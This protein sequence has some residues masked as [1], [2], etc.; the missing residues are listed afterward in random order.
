MK[1]ATPRLAVATP[2]LAHGH[3]EALVVMTTSGARSFFQPLLLFC[4]FASLFLR[5]SERR[6]AGRRRCFHVPSAEQIK[7]TQDFVSSG[8]MMEDSVTFEP[9]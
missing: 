3:T 1:A 9:C 6:A 2:E 5:E 7:A 8:V 4:G